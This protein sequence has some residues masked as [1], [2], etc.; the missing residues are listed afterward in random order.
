MRRTFLIGLAFLAGGLPAPAL[1]QQSDT[2][3]ATM[4]PAPSASPSP[5]PCAGAVVTV[6]G[7]TGRSFEVEPGA[8]ATVHVRVD[9]PTR[10]TLTRGPEQL[11][12][13]DDAIEATWTVPVS[14]RVLHM[15]VTT[16]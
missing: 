2:G 14:D 10:I 6:D 13:A 12:S 5:L 9:Q 1:G 8:E 15:N 16:G 4:S 3:T 7:R 11:R